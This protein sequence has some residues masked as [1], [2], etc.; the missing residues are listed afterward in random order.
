M[1]FHNVHELHW[2]IPYISF[3][4]NCLFQVM[5]QSE[6]G[7]PPP[8]VPM[9]SRPCWPG[10]NVLCFGIFSVQST[11][12][13][14]IAFDILLLSHS[15]IFTITNL[16]GGELKYSEIQNFITLIIDFRFLPPLLIIQCVWLFSALVALVSLKTKTTYLQLPYLF[17]CFLVTA[18]LVALVFKSILTYSLYF[19]GNIISVLIIIGFNLLLVLHI[20]FLYFKCAC[21][22][23]MLRKRNASF[24]NTRS[25]LKWG[26]QTV[27][28]SE[29]H[30]RINIST[31]DAQFDT[32]STQSTVIITDEFLQDPPSP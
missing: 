27:T 19:D 18:G 10:Q 9:D 1:F 3:L 16:V 23:I 7:D 6:I 5:G 28:S 32:Y 20:I 22:R 14:V 12:I 8:S 29:K 30:N 24:R 25:F 4:N 2:M 31:V 17:I 11:F 26:F 13:F 15:L 21:F